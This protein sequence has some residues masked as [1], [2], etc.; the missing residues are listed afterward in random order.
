LKVGLEPASGNSFY[1]IFRDQNKLAVFAYELQ[2]ERTADG[3]HFRVT[4]K[5]AGDD[6]AAR[7]PN[8]DRG[9]PA[10]TLSAPRQSPVL[11]SGERFVIDIPVIPGSAENLSDTVQLRLN[12]RGTPSDPAAQA[13]AALRFVGLKIQIKG[14]LV[15]PAGPGS[16]VA[17]RYVMFY[18]PGRGGY[19]LSAEAIGQPSFVKIGVVDRTHLRFTLDNDDYDCS[20]DAPILS[21]SDRG[22]IW[23]FHDPSYKPSGN[24]TSSDPNSARRDEFFAAASDSL[25]WWLP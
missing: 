10:P 8:A 3:E 17:G 4:A 7:Y 1:R 18:I 19:F 15:S 14:Q 2:V 23:I 24:W 20:S 5:P 12:A 9:K 25:Q 21:R 13:S 11:A 16:T 6:F 22:E